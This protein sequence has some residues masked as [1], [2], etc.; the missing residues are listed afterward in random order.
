MLGAEVILQAISHKPHSV[1]GSDINMGCA[2]PLVDR[3]DVMVCDNSET[4][5]F[6]GCSPTIDTNTSNWASQL[7]T[8]RRRRKV[9][10]LMLR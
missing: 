6:D 4:Y 10:S 2:S 8:V 3:D 9:M 7:V 1:N 5:L